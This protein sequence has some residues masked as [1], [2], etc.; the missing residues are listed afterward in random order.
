MWQKLPVNDFKFV[1]YISEIN[2]DFIKNCNEDDDEGYFLEVDVQ[3]PKNLHSLHSDLSFSLERMK[4]EK[5]EKL[6]ADLHDKTEYIIHTGNLKPALNHGFAL[7][8]VRRIIKLN[9]KAWS[10]PYIEMNTDL[11]KKAKNDF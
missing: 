8:K 1:E 6:V 5:V 3:Y 10:K 9:K 11:R 4:I 7:K 2:K